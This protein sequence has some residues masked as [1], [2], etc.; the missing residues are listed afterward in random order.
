LW[1]IPHF[2]P[3]GVNPFAGRYAAV[4]GSPRGIAHK[5]FTDPMAFVHAVASG[6]KALFLCLL[7][8]PFLGLW[9][10][11][12]LL[13]LGALTDLTINLLSSW[14]NQ[15]S[16]G[17]ENTAGIVPFVVAASIFGAARFKGQALRLSLWV[18]VGAA[19][20]AIF[21]P[22]YVLG[23]DVR[24]LGSPLVSAKSHALGLIPQG[25]PVSASTGLGG[26][27]S[28]R[29]YIYTFP[30]VRRSRWII[31]DINDPTLNIPHF[32]R[33]V[34]SYESNQAWQVLFSS[35]GVS[36]LH[37]RPTTDQSGP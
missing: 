29:R 35:H 33:Q 3:S 34:R 28:E 2:S 18:L 4:G 9:L 24:A 36:V 10:L 32:K 12:P 31:V 19:S 23:G 6:H 7:L 8:V 26:H 13:A 5:L 22:M 27:L 21:S 30:F 17:Y 1:L 25:V 20:V 15:T 11:A 37:R 14:S 16:I